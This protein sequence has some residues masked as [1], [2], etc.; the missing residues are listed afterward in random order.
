MIGSILEKYVLRR[1]VTRTLMVT[2]K[3]VI[4]TSDGFKGNGP[5]A[6]VLNLISDIDTGCLF[7]IS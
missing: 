6:T 4:G 2:I 1:Q 3:D 5:G 7:F